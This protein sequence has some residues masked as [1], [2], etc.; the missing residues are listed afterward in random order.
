MSPAER[1]R[2]LAQALARLVESVQLVRDVYG[3][4]TPHWR[5]IDIDLETIHEHVRALQQ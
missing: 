3:Q 2:L 4:D 5:R 1:F